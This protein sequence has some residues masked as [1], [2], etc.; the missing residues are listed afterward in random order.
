MSCQP[1]L[2]KNWIFLGYMIEQEY[3]DQDLWQSEAVY[4]QNKSYIVMNFW[5]KQFRFLFQ[6]G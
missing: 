4:R 5:L 3:L 6:D 1:K 2:V